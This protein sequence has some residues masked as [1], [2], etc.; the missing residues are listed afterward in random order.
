MLKLIREQRIENA[1]Q[2]LFLRRSTLLAAGMK[3]L[4]TIQSDGKVERWAT[5]DDA[6]A[7]SHL[8]RIV[9]SDLLA[10]HYRAPNIERGP[11]LMPQVGHGLALFRTSGEL[12]KKYVVPMQIVQHACVMGDQTIL[13]SGYRF[14]KM[15][16]W[17]PP[18]PRAVYM[19]NLDSGEATPAPADYAKRLS[20]GVVWARGNTYSQGNI[21]PNGELVPDAS[22]T[23]EDDVEPPEREVEPVFP[24]SNQ[25]RHRRGAFA[26]VVENEVG[27]WAC[28]GLEAERLFAAKS[29]IKWKNYN[30]KF[31]GHSRFI[32][33]SGIGNELEVVN[34][35]SGEQQLLRASNSARTTRSL[36]LFSSHESTLLVMLSNEKWLSWWVIE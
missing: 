18:L 34:V 14:L 22:V 19:L 15:N 3:Q 6:W 8:H 31:V 4:Y 1:D 23:L 11:G 24:K 32:I 35:Q 12:I 9:G 30:F 16:D 29:T 27:I 17:A 26:S 7:D 2:V 10:L 20:S 13:I 36:E 5:F 28:Y 21:G 33:A 25:P